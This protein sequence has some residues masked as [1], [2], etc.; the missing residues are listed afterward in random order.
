MPARLHLAVKLAQKAT[1]QAILDRL[2][3]SYG[4]H[5]N[6][7]KQFEV[8]LQGTTALLEIYTTKTLPPE[9][10]TRIWDLLEC[11]MRSL[12]EAS[13][14]GYNPSAK[15]KELFHPDSR[16]VVLRS[17]PS[18]ALHASKAASSTLLGYSM[19]RF[20]TEETAS[21]DDELCDVVYCYELQVDSSAQGRG[22]GRILMEVLGRVGSH[23]KM[24]KVMLTVFKANA[25]AIAFYKK[26]GF[27]TDEIDPSDYE[28][29]DSAD[30]T[31]LSKPCT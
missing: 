1:T 8:P 29:R 27:S 13:S 9:I 30:Y 19:F 7:E 6:R 23:W 17:A 10:R 11:N 20:D 18:P 14:E 15:R 28:G 16:F 3:N 24:D 5:L 25:P 21:D 12:Y 31:I 2:G 22:V 26:I 4:T